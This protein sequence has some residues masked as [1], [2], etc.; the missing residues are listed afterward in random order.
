MATA[1][2]I[3]IIAIVPRQPV[4][5]ANMAAVV[6][7]MKRGGNAMI[8]RLSRYPSS[9]GGRYVRTGRYGQTWSVRGP[10]RSGNELV[11]VVANNVKDERGRAYTKYVSG[12]EQDDVHKGRWETI[13]EVGDEEFDKVKPAIAAALR[14]RL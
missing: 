10:S 3:K 7:G 14:G 1:P 5:K 13:E 12:D 8:G 9:S 4:V 11:M 2:K 6:A